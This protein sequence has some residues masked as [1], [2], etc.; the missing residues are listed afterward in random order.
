MV[1]DGNGLVAEGVMKRQGS[2]VQCQPRTVIVFTVKNISQQRM[3]DAAHMKTDLVRSS[4]F[5]MNTKQ[6]PV[7]PFLY[8]SVFCVCRFTV[9]MDHHAVEYGIVFHDRQ[10]NGA[11]FFGFSMDNAE[12]L[13]FKNTLLS[14]MLQPLGRNRMLGKNGNA[15]VSLSSR[16]TA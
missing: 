8:F 2:G 14:L 6:G 10:F 5:D 7:F 9:G 15:E 16:P 12:I 13:F 4:G 1:C 3:M 11:V